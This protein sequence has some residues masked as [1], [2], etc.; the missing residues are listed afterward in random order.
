MTFGWGIAMLVAG[1]VL[2]F[3]AIKLPRVVTDVVQTDVVGVILLVMGA[4][5][6]ALGLIQHRSNP[7]GR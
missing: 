7:P 1:A 5:A 2:A 3:E 6:I 4:L